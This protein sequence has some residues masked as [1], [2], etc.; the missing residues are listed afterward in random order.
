MARRSVEVIYYYLFYT[1]VC[2]Y[3]CHFKYSDYYEKNIVLI[4]RYKKYYDW[5]KFSSPT[6]L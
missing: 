6:N 5:V 2:T 1:K 3:Y 4:I